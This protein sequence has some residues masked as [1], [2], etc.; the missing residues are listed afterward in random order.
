MEQVHLIVYCCFGDGPWGEDDS[1]TLEQAGFEVPMK[2]STSQQSIKNADL[3]LRE[4]TE[5][6]VKSME[7]EVKAMDLGGRGE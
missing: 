2:Y 1:F 6:G 5:P 3:E 7:V 4:V